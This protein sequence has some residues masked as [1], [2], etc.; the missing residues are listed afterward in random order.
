MLNDSDII[1]VEC[2][3]CGFQARQTVRV[4]KQRVGQ[5]GLVCGAC[6]SDVHLREA[7]LNHIVASDAKWP[8]DILRLH[9]A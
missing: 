8:F 9:P 7:E 6:Q 3:T 1:I 2:L 5:H 4:L